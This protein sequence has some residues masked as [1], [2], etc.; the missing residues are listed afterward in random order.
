MEVIRD[1]EE[2]ELRECSHRFHALCIMSWFRT[3]H[4]TCPMCKDKGV[5]VSWTDRC[6]RLEKARRA[7]MRKGASIELRRD[8][9]KL[10]RLEAKQ[11]E[12]ACLLREYRNTIT[13]GEKIKTV[14]EQ[15]VKKRRRG[16]YIRAKVRRLKTSIAM[17]HTGKVV[18]IPVR[19]P[20]PTPPTREG[21][22]PREIS[23]GQGP[24]T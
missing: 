7:A 4:S 13:T 11:V 21:L 2:F 12:V 10:K 6:Y 23:T 5:S 1:G 24:L 15:Y 20:V 17:H 3:G 9:A 16:W 14:V 8:V 22:R 19:V 18:A